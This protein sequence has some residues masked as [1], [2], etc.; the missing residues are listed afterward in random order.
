MGRGSN[1]A[2][3]AA[4]GAMA[5]AA[6]GGPWGAAIGGVAGGVLGYFGGDGA[7][8][9]EAQSVAGRANELERQWGN[10]A[11]PQAGPAAQ[12]AYS[13]F[14]GNQQQLVGY[15]EAMSRGQA[16]SLA[17][18][19]LRAAQDRNAA[20]QRGYAAGARGPSAGLA[21][22]NAA[23]NVAAL[24]ARS[25]Q[26]AAQ[27]R[28][29]EQQMALQQLGLTLHGARGADE[30][31]NTFNTGQINARDQANLEARLRA[32]GMTDESQI[33]ALALQLQAGGQAIPGPSMGDQI[34]AGGANAYSMF[35]T[36]GKGQAAPPQRAGGDPLTN[37]YRN[38]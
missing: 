35:G 31:V 30:N 25:G 18:A 37:M 38:A 11:A 17:E 19:Q 5:G 27:A 16:P 1:A 6:I 10:R 29:A 21:N 36:A 33:R 15:L 34:L 12:A 22:F 24:G 8:N 9:E 28:I 32:M 13:G 23:N 3:G 26:D 20:Q 2:K 14:R 7:K 4:G